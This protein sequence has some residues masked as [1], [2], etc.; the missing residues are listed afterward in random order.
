MRVLLALGVILMSLALGQATKCYFSVESKYMNTARFEVPCTSQCGKSSAPLPDGSEMTMRA[1]V[2]TFAQMSSPAV[3]NKLPPEQRVNLEGVTFG[4]IHSCSGEL[5][6][7]A[8]SILSGSL[9][10]LCIGIIVA[11]VAIN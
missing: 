10:S 1:C 2:D 4:E 6:N 5:C 7:G 9:L 8:H 11:L 3:L